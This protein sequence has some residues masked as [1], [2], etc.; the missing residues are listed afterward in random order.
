[1]GFIHNTR[2][3]LLIPYRK[4]QSSSVIVGFNDKIVSF[5]SDFGMPDSTEEL[6]LKLE[7]IG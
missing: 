3:L 6:K 5:Y 2:Q 7:I 4:R 1:M